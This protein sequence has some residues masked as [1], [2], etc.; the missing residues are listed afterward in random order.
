MQSIPKVLLY[1]SR[2]DE[3]DEYVS[4]LEPSGARMDLIVCRAAGEVASAIADV[5]IVFGVHL[6]ADAYPAARNLKWIQSMWAGVEGLLSA[7]IDPSVRITKPVGVFGAL[8]SQ[9]VFAY[10]LADSVKLLQALN[11]QNE[12]RWQPYRIDSLRGKK[13]GIAGIG[14]IGSDIARAARV[15]DMDVW[16]LNSDGRPHPLARKTFAPDA[17]IEFASSLDVLV[18][19]LPNTP[20]TC[21]LFAKDVLNSLKSDCILINIGRGAVIDDAALLEILEKNKIK[22][23]VLDV[24]TVEP[25]PAQH[26]YW[27]LPNCR[28]TPHIGGP[29]IPRDITNAFLENFDRYQSGEPLIGEVDRKRGY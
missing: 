9:Y 24:F 11:C 19:A 21:G 4:L 18:I 22:L 2:P 12:K 25:L 28:V 3:I 1:V 6:P 16:G 5:E 29:S 17:I 14:D 15:F 20:S 27:S 13:I 8:L 23:A 10:L 7:S 26:P